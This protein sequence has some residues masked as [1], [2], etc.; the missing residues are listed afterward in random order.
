MIGKPSPVSCSLS[1]LRR[2]TS[3][4]SHAKLV[5]SLESRLQSRFSLE[6]RLQSRLLSRISS[7]IS[8]LSNLV[9]DLVSISLS[10]RNHSFDL[11]FMLLLFVILC[12]LFVV[13]C[14]CL[15]SPEVCD[16]DHKREASREE[17]EEEAR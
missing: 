7:Q 15:L 8:F 12:S 9:S 2:S 10:V 4:S 1:L 5:F 16:K 11:I 14:S 6:S 17:D 13:L 3:P